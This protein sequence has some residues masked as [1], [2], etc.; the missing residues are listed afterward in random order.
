MAALAT[1]RGAP[2]M[3]VYQ[4][5]P[6]LNAYIYICIMYVLYIWVL[7]NDS[8]SYCIH[9][10]IVHSPCVC[11]HASVGDSG[12]LSS[13]QQ[14]AQVVVIIY[15]L[16]WVFRKIIVQCRTNWQRHREENLTWMINY[17][18]IVTSWRLPRYCTAV[19]SVKNWGVCACVCVMS[20][21]GNVEA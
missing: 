13:L 19:C 12:V 15:L 21:D 2:L 8:V 18:C 14:R 3:Y 4:S 9:T 7:W 5:M 6:F 16:A 17:S 20:S 11:I 10:L 1:P